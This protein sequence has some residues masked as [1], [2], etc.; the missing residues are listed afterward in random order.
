[1]TENNQGLTQEELN[2]IYEILLLLRQQGRS[3][4]E[5]GTDLRKL[6]A[7]LYVVFS[8]VGQVTSRMTEEDVN[9]IVNTLKDLAEVSNKEF[10]EKFKEG[11]QS[12]IDEARERGVDVSYLYLINRDNVQGW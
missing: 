11:A 9:K 4:L 8:D 10:K 2:R 3:V 6:Y 5:I 7:L 12:A 1:M